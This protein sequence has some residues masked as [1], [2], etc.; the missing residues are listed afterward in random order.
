ML[1][2]IYTAYKNPDICP[3]SWFTWLAPTIVDLLYLKQKKGNVSKKGYYFWDP[4]YISRNWDWFLRYVVKRLV[5]SFKN[6]FKTIKIL[7]CTTAVILHSKY[8]SDLKHSF[9]NTGIQN[10]FIHHQMYCHWYLIFH[11]LVWNS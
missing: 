7:K 11:I 10:K 2:R 3:H 6:N 8:W 5:K 9:K 4:S 1:V